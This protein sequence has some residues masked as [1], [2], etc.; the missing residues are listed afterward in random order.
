MTLAL[1]DPFAHMWADEEEE[2]PFASMWA[3]SAP[4]VGDTFPAPT[5]PYAPL[6]PPVSR[7]IRS[8]PVSIAP[9]IE[10]GLPAADTGMFES[11]VKETQ[12]P[13]LVRGIATGWYQQNPEMF[14]GGVE[15]IGRT[16]NSGQLVKMGQEMGKKRPLD[17]A[18]MMSAVGRGKIED[19]KN[20]DELLTW[21]GEQAGQGIASSGPSLAANL[22]GRGIGAAAGGAM[23]GPAM[24]LVGQKVG[25]VALSAIPSYLMNTGDLYSALKD[26]GVEEDKAARQATKYGG[27]VT[28]YDVGAMEGII[29]GLS[30]PIRG[31]FFAVVAKR[32]AAGVALEGTTEAIQ[33]MIQM[34]VV[35]AA[36]GKKI[37]NEERRSQVFNSL[38]AG[39]A[40]GGFMAAGP[41][42]VGAA[43]RK[44]S[45]VIAPQPK[46]VPEA[47]PTAP[48]AELTVIT[49]DEKV[50]LI[51][52]IRALDEKPT[53]WIRD[54][55]G[56]KIGEL[57]Y[58]DL[59]AAQRV[60]EVP[61]REGMPAGEEYPKAKRPQ[62]GQ[63]IEVPEEAQPRG[64]ALAGPL[65]APVA[66]EPVRRAV[67]PQKPA[68]P[69]VAV[70]APAAT[71]T[72]RPSY[73][74][75]AFPEGAKGPE[76]AQRKLRGA[77]ARF[78]QDKGVWRMAT[79]GKGLTEEIIAQRRAL[80]QE[81]GAVEAGA[82][83][84]A[85]EPG[86]IETAE[87]AQAG[88]R[89]EPEPAME[90]GK[91]APAEVK[92]PWEMTEAEWVE[93]ANQETPEFVKAGQQYE[94][95]YVTSNAWDEFRRARE[96]ENPD[97]LVS[98]HGRTY[99]DTIEKARAWLTEH[100]EW[101]GSH[102]SKVEQALAEGKPVPAEVLAEYPELA[103]E[104]PLTPSVVST[105]E[106]AARPEV[107]R[108]EGIELPAA[109]VGSA[110]QV[111]AVTAEDVSRLAG[112]IKQRHGLF[113]M[114][115]Y[116]TN[117]GHLDLSAIEVPMGQRGQGIGSAAMQDLV[118]FADQNG[119]RITLSPA[120]QDKRHGT[121]SRTRLVKFYKQFGFVQNKGRNT[122]HS[123]S[124]GMYREP[125]KIE[126]AE[127][128]V[129][130]A[131][132]PFSEVS[133]PEL[134]SA[135]ELEALIGQTERELASKQADIETQEQRIDLSRQKGSPEVIRRGQ[136]KRLNNLQKE[137]F[138]LKDTISK[139][140]GELDALQE[141]AA[142]KPEAPPGVVAFA[143]RVS[144]D[145]ETGEEGVLRDEWR[146]RTV[147][148]VGEAAL[149]AQFGE[150]WRSIRPFASHVLEHRYIR[151]GVEEPWSP[152]DL[153]NDR[154]A[155]LEYIDDKATPI[156]PVLLDIQEG[157]A[158]YRQGSR[159]VFAEALARET[160]ER[161]LETEGKREA[162]RAAFE[163]LRAGKDAVWADRWNQ[164]A[165]SH[166]GD[167]AYV[168][169][170]AEDPELMRLYD[171]AMLATTVPK[172]KAA[173]RRFLEYVGEEDEAPGVGIEGLPTQQR[174][175]ALVTLPEVAEVAEAEEP[176]TT[177]ESFPSPTSR[178]DPTNEYLPTQMPM[179]LD[180]PAGERAAV[181]RVV[182][183]KATAPRIIHQAEKVI[184]SLG[185]T[186]PIRVGRAG[187]GKEGVYKVHPAVVRL[188]KANDVPVA[189]HEIAHAIDHIL[190]IQKGTKLSPPPPGAARELV[191]LGK[192]IY[193][194]RPQA[195]WKSEG[196]AQYLKL[197]ASHDTEAQSQAPQF[198]AWFDEEVRDKHPKTAKELD[199]LRDMVTEYRGVGSTER[200]A[201]HIAT[202][203]WA[204]KAREVSDVGLHRVF[205]LMKDKALTDWSSMAH[206][207]DQLARAG[208]ASLG[209][210]LGI[211]EDPGRISRALAGR[212]DK[213]V[214][215]WVRGDGMTD[216]TGANVVGPSLEQ[217]LVPVRGQYS[218]FQKYLL[219]RR[220]RAL[221]NDPKGV[222]EVGI[223]PA[224][225]EQA[226]ADL[227]T[228]AMQEA[229]QGWYDWNDGV[230]NYAA[231]HS[232]VFAQAVEAMRARDPG[233][234]APLAREFGL[235]EKIYRRMGRGRG[236]QGMPG[237][238]LVGSGRRVKN[239]IPVAIA[240]ARAMALASHKRF[241]ADQILRL[242]Q[243]E[244]MGN[245][246]EEVP[247][248][249][250]PKASVELKEV[251]DKLHREFGIN[252][253]E[254]GDFD[255]SAA[256]M[257]FYGVMDAPKGKDP[258]IAD[259]TK[260]GVKWYYVKDAA[261]MEAL[262]A[263]ET[264]RDV[265]RAVT[266]FITT[267][268]RVFRLGTTGLSPRF[269]LV[270][271]LIKD[272]PT[273]LLNSQADASA[274]QFFGAWL[275]SLKDGALAQT[276]LNDA[277]K[278]AGIDN[279][280]EYYKLWRRM[281]G[282]MAQPLGQDVAHT[283]RA[284]RML[285][286]SWGWRLLDARNAVDLFREV[287]QFPESAPRVAELRLKAKELGWD[288]TRP[289][290]Q[291]EAL[292][293]AEVANPITVDFMD[294][295]SKARRVNM[296][297]PFFTAA[298]GG[299]RRAIQVTKADPTRVALRGLIGLTLP[300]LAL[301][302]LTRDEEWYKQMPRREKFMNWH[303]PF[304]FDERK[305]MS[306]I[307]RPF[308]Y[309]MYFSALPEALMDAWYRQ[310]PEAAA[311]WLDLTLETTL[312]PGIS[313]S[314]P[315]QGGPLPGG[316]TFVIEA[317]LVQTYME[318][319]ANW[320][321]FW[322]QPIVPRRLQ[323]LP[324]EQQYT[325]YTT[326]AAIAIGKATNTS[327]MRVDHMIQGVFG[328]VSGEVLSLGGRGAQ[329][330]KFEKELADI[331]VLG[332]L[333]MRGG[334]E[335]RHPL[336][337][338]ELYELADHHRLRQYDTVAL[339]TADEK[340]IRLMLGDATRAM[341]AL[342]AVRRSVT[343]RDGKDVIN[344][345]ILAL[346]KAAVADAHSYRIDRIK[347][348]AARR[349]AQDQHDVAR[350]STLNKDDRRT[351][352]VHQL[353]RWQLAPK[354]SETQAA[355]EAALVVLGGSIGGWR[356]YYD[357]NKEDMDQ[358]SRRYMSERIRELADLRGE[359]NTLNGPPAKEAWEALNAVAEPYGG[360]GSFYQRIRK[361]RAWRLKQGDSKLKR[362]AGEPMIDV[363]IREAA[364]R[365][366]AS[367]LVAVQ[368]PYQE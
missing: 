33:Q 298:I 59:D 174:I 173:I 81:L 267:P 160:D 357:A 25:A 307:P 224:D 306:R 4:D 237:G 152:A 168:K 53:A 94:D 269:S 216:W 332:R 47:Q 304:E 142:E 100:P 66:P 319:M 334:Q 159:A 262:G 34:D 218:D 171:E 261:L 358:A 36:T 132:A 193:D 347:F 149:V 337:V 287:I 127:L 272:L 202:G 138:R 91:A 342:Y 75:I 367:P 302:R 217:A 115:V 225:A 335:P 55:L 205:G 155:A 228:P 294:V 290:T 183:G 148:K 339:E 300:T 49:Q 301:W 312:P 60:L 366:G 333:F 320:Q 165:A 295:G 248:G 35:E 21:L 219:A 128:A 150:D 365:Y 170:A 258:I 346:A 254:T 23:G 353:G 70:P 27:I 195:G 42:A 106:P 336:A 270:T 146:V 196:F 208:E 38:A 221:A 203:S 16:L 323:D 109:T 90:R 265:S 286:E 252:V 206:P 284:A 102:E 259:W 197:W 293:M 187:R 92:E 204:E 213:R 52:Q 48:M 45:G 68:E 117:Q 359:I 111:P 177:V 162:S 140:R 226:V 188:R 85:V 1:R 2:D 13:A 247:K 69:K 368:T 86:E 194:K 72:E 135:Q 54:N 101:A 124:A 199:V 8:S 154:R 260:D 107:D 185:S 316:R 297:I 345:E 317:P 326:R 121:T 246:I 238:R 338:D 200:I 244:G 37:E 89:G 84:A 28:F 313:V 227:E 271:N 57:T 15:A 123:I 324:A 110:A 164:F 175:E 87:K 119:L 318:Q 18:Y 350:A 268:A 112:E 24:A 3:T 276:H 26:A 209:R 264:F 143:E 74:E 116:L 223:T 133:I 331:P 20:L 134:S 309:G 341:T 273:A 305:E 257:T 105:A 5:P 88:V 80:A 157:R 256:M 255:L 82:V 99:A 253:E 180:A 198:S 236:T 7:D 211:E 360:W 167:K 296:G 289:V 329:D 6:Y 325:D 46:V 137:V 232:P 362:R 145:P 12:A 153:G 189:I 17:R 169:N 303:I 240:N 98:T 125:Q 220:V 191:K 9:S 201:R 355:A 108:E 239:P 51:K 288:G 166:Q 328:G 76:E 348:A 352:M 79:R 62:P 275:A 179:R 308:E 364:A 30:R 327:P 104:A 285:F 278:K 315:P 136:V 78:W 235:F 282:P 361:D 93:N 292:Q 241:I 229:A 245:L 343:A 144:A 242:A 215:S 214:E 251:L 266:L 130:A 212:H 147:G 234:Y 11:G 14:G 67:E 178:A 61:V 29:S 263:Q 340:T 190:Y 222:R 231:Q 186:V 279:V 349:D 151:R 243:L 249:R 103:V 281:G 181:A 96:Y 113:E 344:R 43:R 131:E 356:S 71:V 19:V 22:I 44:D 83:P 184:E 233:D 65:E 64:A 56:K 283:K 172:K 354:G 321:S 351:A 230:L 139:A 126:A 176:V 39:A 41:T 73:I 250:E 330:M 277:L 63:R 291:S 310:N 141:E 280:S 10:M 299:V 97:K 322:E 95:E 156:D 58:A 161:R 50:S 311:A 114:Q 163:R 363:W 120:L 40:T 32:I 182:H 158:K 207:L 77:K 274:P 210:K 129:E 122:D 314:R 31:R 118:E 192:Q